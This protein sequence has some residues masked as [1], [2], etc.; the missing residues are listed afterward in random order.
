MKAVFQSAVLSLLGTLAGCAIGPTSPALQ[1]EAMAPLLPVRDFVASVDYNGNYRISP[2]GRKLAWT[3]VK[4]ARESLFVKALDTGKVTVIPIKGN[5]IWAQDSRHMFFFKDHRGDENYHVMMLDLEHPEKASRDLTPYKHTRAG[6]QRIIQSDPAHVLIVHNR[7]DPKVFDLVKVELSSGREEVVAI[8]PGDVRSWLTDRDGSLWGRVRQTPDRLQLELH[9]D[10]SWRVVTHWDRFDSMAPVELSADRRTVWM[11]SNRGRDKSALVRFDLQTG[12]ETVVYQHPVTDVGAVWFSQRSRTPLLAYVEP[13]YPLVEYFDKSLE[14]DMRTMSPN[15]PHGIRLSSLDD[16][17]R[18]MTVEVFTSTGKRFYFY[19]RQTHEKTLLGESSSARFPG[20]LAAVKPVSIMSRDGL[21]L[22]GYL[23]L[24]KNISPVNLPTVL[25]VHGGPWFRDTWGYDRYTN[26]LAQFL[27]NRGY[28]VLQLNYRGSLGYGQKFMQAA[29]GEFGGK[30]QDDLIDGVDWLVKQKISD[31]KRIGIM[32]RSFGGYAT[33]AGL[34]FTPRTFACGVSIVG[35][36]DLTTQRGPE[37]GQLGRYWWDRYIGSTESP[38]DRERL[39]QRSPY[40]HAA[41]FQSPVLIIYGAHDA[42]VAHGQSEKM[43]VA[44]REAGKQVKS[45]ELK[46]EGHL[47]RR[48]PSNLKMYRSIE[49]F[50]AGCL[51]GRSAGFDFYE[52]GAWAF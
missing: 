8:N 38:A 16:Q 22:H 51:G 45:I 7:R 11:L 43:V 33:L 6:L 35:V 18:R 1:T 42:R 36:S 2:D 3:A 30:A 44:L 13:D 19:D 34:A 25:L 9:D 26:R 31:P 20:V 52:L 50:L 46:E 27:A 41:A 14:A 5:F 10:G 15:E 28:A 21:K 24:P 12:R 47:I 39:R 40:Y 48:W 32:G 17:D 29:I 49:D 37:Y 23:T 4:G